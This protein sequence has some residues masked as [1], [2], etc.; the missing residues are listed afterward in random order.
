MYLSSYCSGE[1]LIIAAPIAFPMLSQ[2]FISY[3]MGFGDP[4]FGVGLRPGRGHAGRQCCVRNLA[5]TPATD[6]TPGSA[7]SHLAKLTVIIMAGVP[8]DVLGLLS[9]FIPLGSHIWLKETV[10]DISLTTTHSATSTCT[11][12][13]GMGKRRPRAPHSF[14]EPHEKS[15]PS[16]TSWILA[17]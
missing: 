7:G 8:E 13:L 9:P 16:F 10:V 6:R 17:Q 14:T 3:G 5:L 15:L 2:I 4:N 1:G 12:K 11:F